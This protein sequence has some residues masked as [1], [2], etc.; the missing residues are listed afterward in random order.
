MNCYIKTSLC[1]LLLAAT[2]HSNAQNSNQNIDTLAGRFIKELRLD[3]KEKIFVQ[4]NKWFYVAGEELWLKAYVINEL[5][6]KYYSQSKTLYVDLV[7]DKDT[8][9]AQLLLNIPK[10]H[11]EGVIP[12]SIALPEGYY[13]LRAYT[14]NM[15]QHDTSSIFVLPIYIVNKRFAPA[16]TAEA[17]NTIAAP[18]NDKPQ[19]SFYPEGGVLIDNSDAVIGF[20]A[21][22]QQGQPM[23]VSGTITDSYGKEVT[24]F[25]TDSSG[26]GKFNYH[27]FKSR[28]CTAHIKWNNQDLSWPLP[29]VNHFGSQISVL[30]ENADN[31]KALVIL[32]DSIYEKDKPT[33]LLGISRDSLCFASVG[34]GMYEVNIPKKNFPDGIA[35]LYLFNDQQQVVSE[36]AIYINK[37]KEDIVIKTDKDNYKRRDKVTLTIAAGD[38][39]LNPQ[40]AALSVSVTDDIFTGQPKSPYAIAYNQ[41]EVTSQLSDNFLLTQPQLY[42]GKNFNKAIDGLAATKSFDADSSI[43]DI[44]GKIL[45][46]KNQPVPNR[47]VTLYSTKQINLFTSATTNTSGQFTFPLLSYPD[48]VEFTIQVSDQ[49]GTKLNERIIVEASPFPQLATP[50][51]LKRKLSSQQMQQI[52]SFREKYLDDYVIGT[53]N[54]W[55]KEVKVAS[56]GTTYNHSKRVST[57]SNI[58]PGEAVKRISVTNSGLALLSMPGVHLNG[59]AI[60]IGSRNSIGGTGAADG[61]VHGSTY[62]SEEPLLI[63]DG[64]EASGGIMEQMSRISPDIIDFIEV[65]SGAEAAI[66]GYRGSNGVVV[67]NTL[68]ISNVLHNVSE[69]V[70]MLKYSPKSY[71]LPPDYTMP[72]YNNEKIKNTDFQDSR[73]TLYWNGHVYTNAKGKAVLS[74][75]TSDA[76]GTYTIT[77][78]GI[79]V[80][81]DIIYKQASFKRK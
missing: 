21:T 80:N 77:V 5:S 57:F 14:T 6:H 78:S 55:L 13:W 59:E 70:G 27:T 33:Y 28:K 48:S 11:T 49:K 3:T 46:N 32:G 66:Y 31:I 7:N 64:S 17:K 63:I 25:K 71:H 67:V 62:F 40:I 24:G 72:D 73:Y 51:S 53:G 81:G 58:L 79:T 8:A 1:F 44:K 65:L 69:G 15:L 19:L 34:E 36:R 16:F 20:K 30:E 54:K 60:Q 26:L 39:L 50:E 75:F 41:I 47:I 37:Q 76:A 43:T 56:K 18:V 61:G 68:N 35:T 45:N 9:I 10:Q 42:K 2:I 23:Q 38:S 4:T 22:N 29:A 52:Q 12:L 74:F